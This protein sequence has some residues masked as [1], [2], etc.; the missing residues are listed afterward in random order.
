MLTDGRITCFNK[1]SRPTR[2]R[3]EGGGGGGGGAVR[4]SLRGSFVSFAQC[5][6]AT[7]QLICK[8]RGG[9]SD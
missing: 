3:G 8:E 9:Y 1:V 6:P 4:L 7:K 5:S 2:S